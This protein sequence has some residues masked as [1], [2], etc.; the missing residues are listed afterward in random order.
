MKRRF[1]K[2][3]LSLTILENHNLLIVVWFTDNQVT[4]KIFVDYQKKRWGFENDCKRR[5]VK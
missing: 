3:L 1:K 4:K 2:K 5:I